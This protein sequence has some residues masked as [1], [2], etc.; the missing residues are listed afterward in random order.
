M[1]HGPGFPRGSVA[2]GKKLDRRV[3]RTGPG[4]LHQARLGRGG[5]PSLTREDAP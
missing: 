2:C 1:C 4:A 5:P 3:A